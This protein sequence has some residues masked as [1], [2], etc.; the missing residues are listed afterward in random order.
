MPA[1]NGGWASEIALDVEWSHAIAPQAKILLV[2]ANDSSYANLFAAV[3]YAAKQPGVVAVS[4]SW[5]G[6]EFTGENSYDSVFTTPTGHTGVTFIASSG[7]SG[8]PASYP[9]ASPNVLAVGGTTLNVDSSG[10]ILSESGWSGSGGG[11]SSVESEPSYQKSVVPSTLT[12]TRRANPD[13]AYDADPYTGFPV[14]DSYNNGTSAPWSQFGGTSDAAPQW[15]GLMAIVAQGRI[16]A[17]LTAL[18]G[19]SQTL[20][21]LY[22][23]SAADFHDITSGTSAG[24]PHYSASTAYDLVTGRG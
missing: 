10:N 5:G 2:E 23:L 8:A 18:D 21:K 1:A 6:G 3:T 16:Q 22:G 13:V 17:G 14:Y 7:D 4:M 15:A 20:P 24:L 12:T 9:A 11:L 19:P